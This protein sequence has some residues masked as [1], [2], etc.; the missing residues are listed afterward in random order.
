MKKGILKR[1]RTLEYVLRTKR[2]TEELAEIDSLS[3]QE[4]GALLCRLDKET[5]ISIYG[6]GQ[7][8]EFIAP[9]SRHS[10]RIQKRAR[11]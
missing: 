8:D 6:K 7:P 5:P 2:G 3:D 1:I 4:Q 10:R 9:C 11:G